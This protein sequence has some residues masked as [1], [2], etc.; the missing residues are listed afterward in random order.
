MAKWSDGVLQKP[1]I[2]AGKKKKRQRL[3]WRYIGRRRLSM[4][5]LYTLMGMDNLTV[6]SSRAVEV[7][8]MSRLQT[9]SYSPR[10][11][12]CELLTYPID[13]AQA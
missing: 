11:R 5:Y 4:E 12:H 2:A 8:R 3:V 10:L 1:I 7:D 9:A 6:M 13:L